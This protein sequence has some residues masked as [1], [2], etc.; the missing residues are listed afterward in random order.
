MTPDDDLERGIITATQLHRGGDTAGAESCLR[1]LLSGHPQ[2]PDVRYHLD[3]TLGPGNDPTVL[4]TPGSSYPRIQQLFGACYQIA[5]LLD[6]AA[7]CY[8]EGLAHAPADPLLLA[9]LATVL[10]NAG[11]LDE[12][13]AGHLA[14]LR[15]GAAPGPVH[16]RLGNL[17][18]RQ[19][20]LELAIAAL[21]TAVHADPHA[22]LA[23]NNLGATLC[24]LGRIAEGREHFQA[25]VTIQPHYL[26]AQVN[27]G[28]AFYALREYAAARTV[29]EAA[30][31][32]DSNLPIVHNNLGAILHRA[33]DYSTAETCFRNALRLA[34]QYADAR[35]NL[36]NAQ[37][38]QG[39]ADEAEKSYRSVLRLSPDQPLL[40]LQT[41]SLWPAVFPSRDAI[42]RYRA[43]LLEFLEEMAAKRLRLPPDALV[44]AGLYPPYGLMYHGQDDLP[45]KRAY[46]AVFQNCFTAREPLKRNRRPRIGMVVTDRHEGI[47]SRSIKGVIRTMRRSEFDLI[48]ACSQR[49]AKF[50]SGE[51]ADHVGY[52]ILPE[53]LTGAAA[54]LETAACDVLYHWEVGTDALNYFLPFERLAP[55]QCTSWGL[56]VTSGIPTMDYYLS[57]GE[58][59][60]PDA[61]H[62]YSEALIKAQALLSYQ[63]REPVPTNLKSRAEFGLPEGR[64]LYL[65]AQQIGKFHPEFDA[66]LAAILR[67]D[68]RGV[69]VITRDR[70]DHHARRLLERFRITMPDVV[71]R[72]LL[73]PRMDHQHYLAL[74]ATADVVL[75]PPCYGGVNTTYDALSL[76]TPV[77]TMR[78]AYHIAR[79][80]A[81]CV[82]RTQA[83][84]CI[85]VDPEDYARRAIQLG[86]DSAFRDAMRAM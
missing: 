10:E 3:L 31:A 45:I 58:V 19:G 40:E 72:V 81:A 57:A 12:A 24:R 48:I 44:T 38:Q 34:P 32:L 83:H 36:A 25:A 39:K 80:S 15:A 60:P 67:A 13:V 1:R 47:F 7:R 70:W 63:Y 86:T 9:A 56:Q 53:D 16:N 41:R 33:G 74:V 11:Q 76:G 85:A 50:L 75:D 51:L 66:V 49:G 62:H 59:E 73:L 4:D 78:G 71:D 2:P 27:L 20:H 30:L 8:R 28:N 29:Y 26:D 65:C 52:V 69:L 68:G 82:A 35:L 22:A 37:A 14:A 43:R 46:A 84:G 42:L 23:H 54:A 6:Q 5:G 21:Q 55:V 79:Y 64:H 18:L 17:Y 77:V 61:E